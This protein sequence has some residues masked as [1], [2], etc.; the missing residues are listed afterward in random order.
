MAKKLKRKKQ[1]TLS[2]KRPVEIAMGEHTAEQLVVLTNQQA[3]KLLTIAFLDERDNARTL[4]GTR[5]RPM[6]WPPR[7]AA[8]IDSGWNAVLRKQ[9]RDDLRV[10]AKQEYFRFL[11]MM[12]GDHADIDRRVNVN[13]MRWLGYKMVKG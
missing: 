3:A 1:K 10:A 4:G 6:A 5:Q 12:N 13:V 2:I 8:S 7:K 11:R 9:P